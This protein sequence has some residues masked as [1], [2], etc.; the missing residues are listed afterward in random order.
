MIRKQDFM[1]AFHTFNLKILLWFGKMQL[2]H[3]LM[4][5]L[6]KEENLFNLCQLQDNL[7]FTLLPLKMLRNLA[8]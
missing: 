6:I 7:I 4:F 3:G 8:N 1:Q 2:K 5:G